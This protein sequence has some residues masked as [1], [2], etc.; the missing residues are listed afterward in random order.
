[1]SKS[2]RPPPDQAELCKRFKESLDFL[3][4]TPS[5]AYIKLGYT[6]PST[7]YSVMAGRCFPDMTKLV[8]LSK[9]RA[10]NGR[11]INIDW[12]VT[13]VGPKAYPSSRRHSSEVENLLALAPKEKL[14]ALA[15]LIGD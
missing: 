10:S 6:T 4:L 15:I 14:E 9:L 13:G 3:G 12:L 5:S 2:K 11:R 8:A 1:M 7:L